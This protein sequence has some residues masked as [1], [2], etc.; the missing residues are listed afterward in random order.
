[1]L[2]STSALIAKTWLGMALSLIKHVV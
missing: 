2:R 1:L